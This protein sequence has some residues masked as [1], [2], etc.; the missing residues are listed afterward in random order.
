M[1]R[2]RLRGLGFVL[3][4]LALVVGVGARPASAETLRLKVMRVTYGTSQI[5][6]KQAVAKEYPS[7]SL[8]GATYSSSNTRTATV[9]SQGIVTVRQVAETDTVASRQQSTLT[10]SSPAGICGEFRNRT[11]RIYIS[12]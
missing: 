7:A 3:I 9:S 1:D 4:V 6:F 5:D 2:R 11:P 10:S 8:T 12:A